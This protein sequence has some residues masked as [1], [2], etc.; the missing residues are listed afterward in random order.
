MGSACVFNYVKQTGHDFSKQEKPS[1]LAGFT[2]E[3]INSNWDSQPPGTEQKLI[4]RGIWGYPF[5]FFHPRSPSSSAR[6]GKY[7]ISGLIKHNKYI[8][9]QNSISLAF[10][11]HQTYAQSKGK[12][13]EEKVSW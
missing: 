12:K 2:W 8:I 1:S 9:C 6:S 7:C 5:R 4:C 10:K 3:K 11:C 13:E